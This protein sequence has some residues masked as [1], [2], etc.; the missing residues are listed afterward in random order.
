MICAAPALV[1]LLTLAAADT[2][3]VV[4]VEA[5]DAMQGLGAQVT[6]QVLEA[7]EAMKLKV[8]T[9]D[10]LKALLPPEKYAE[11]RKCRASTACVAQAI[12]GA[13]V[14]R[15]IVGS[16]GRDE[17][18]YLLR[19]WHHDVKKGELVADVDRAVL[20]A[21]R[22]LQRDVE[23]AV[24]P[25]LRGEQEARGTLVVESNVATAEVLLNGEPAGPLPLRVQLKPG[26]HEV[27]L[28]K[29][30]Y[31][32]VTRLVTVEANQTTTETIKLL[33]MPGQTDEEALP[34]LTAQAPKG[35]APS[36]VSLS[37]PTF[38]AGGVTVAA[39][40][41]ATVFGLLAGG[42]ERSLLAGLDEASGVYQGTRAQALTQNRD[43]LIANVSFVA[44]GVAAVATVVLLVVDLLGNPAA[45][46]PAGGTP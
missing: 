20:I 44:L 14:A 23:Q 40:V 3:A 41:S 37:V 4:D 24:P 12:G 32:P 46:A 43:A 34:K 26:K 22:R 13:G 30:R 35:E 42:A 31:L 27:R 29:D 7:A 28:E 18:S 9:P 25:L 10:Q 11:L 17:K 5:A 21:S 2:W 33:L 6:R 45:A 8:V 38:I 16:L 15:V 39:G 1:S 19:L 36:A